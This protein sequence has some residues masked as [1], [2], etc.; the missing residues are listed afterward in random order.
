MSVLPKVS[1]NKRV[2]PILACWKSAKWLSILNCSWSAK[3]KKFYISPV[4]EK[5]KTS[6]L[7]GKLNLIQRVPLDTLPQELVASLPHNH[8][9]LTDLFIS[10]YRGL[11]LPN[12]GSKNN[13]LIEFHRTLLQVGVVTSL[14]F[15]HVTLIN[16]YISIYRETT[17]AT[18]IHANA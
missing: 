13:S 5:V 2:G 3:L 7:D 10:S 17:R 18:F 9:T 4:M 16:L 8:V 15:N 14:L 1:K 12:L 11:L 6:G